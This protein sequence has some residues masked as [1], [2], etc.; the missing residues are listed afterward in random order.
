MRISIQI[1]NGVDLYFQDERFESTTFETSY[2]I[3]SQTMKD[4]HYYRQQIWSRM[5]LFDWQIDFWPWPVLKVKVKVGHISTVNSQTVTDMAN[6]STTS[7]YKVA[8][9]LV[10]GIFTFDLGPFYRLGSRSCTVPLH[11]SC[12][13][14]YLHSTFAHSKGQRQGHAHFYSKYLKN[15]DR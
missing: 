5:S 7:N 10:F 6:I 14:A 12:R 9:G 8:W 3:I 13:L 4:K 11:L 15:G 1:V 2:V